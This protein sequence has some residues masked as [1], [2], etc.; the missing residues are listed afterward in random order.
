MIRRPP[1]STLFPYTTLFRSKVNLSTKW[2]RRS[3]RELGF[4]AEQ[5]E[6]LLWDRLLHHELTRSGKKLIVDKTPNNVFIVDRLRAAW[7]D[8]RFVFLLRHPA[9]IA[10]S[11]QKLRPADADNDANIQLIARYCNALEEARQR[12][13]GV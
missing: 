5:L 4:D 8:A 7:P 12:F 3:I 13:D 9:A 2:S 6:C 11:R 10:R 1:R